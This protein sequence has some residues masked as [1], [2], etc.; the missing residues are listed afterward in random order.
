MRDAIDQ[1]FDAI[2]DIEQ[3]NKNRLQ[4]LEPSSLDRDFDPETAR[5]IKEVVFPKRALVSLE[6]QPMVCS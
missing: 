4:L 1:A 6:I 5:Q 3:T 2:M